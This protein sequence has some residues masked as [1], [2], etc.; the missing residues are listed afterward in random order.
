M[1]DVRLT[2]LLYGI[3]GKNTEMPACVLTDFALNLVADLQKACF[4]RRKEQSCQS[5]AEDHF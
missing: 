3:L 4:L 1:P 5:T 2:G